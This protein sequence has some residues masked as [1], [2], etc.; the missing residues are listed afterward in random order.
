MLSPSPTSLGVYLLGRLDPLFLG[1]TNSLRVSWLRYGLKVI[2]VDADWSLWTWLECRPVFLFGTA[3]KNTF[4]Y[5]ITDN[6][7]NIVNNM[8]GIYETIKLYSNYLI[9]SKKIY[10][11]Q[12]PKIHWNTTAAAATLAMKGGVW[13]WLHPHYHWHTPFTCISS[14]APCSAV[15]AAFLF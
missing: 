10:N 1:S 2:Q 4:V 9:Y 8:N 15:E 12:K 3:E 6:L 11:Y 14:E 13:C 5:P 7:E